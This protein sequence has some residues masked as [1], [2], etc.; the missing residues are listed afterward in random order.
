MS[1]SFDVDN[2]GYPPHNRTSFQHVQ[3][4]FPT[5]RIRRGTVPPAPWRVV[6]RDV[7]ALRYTTPDGHTRSVREMI[8]ASFTDAFLVAKGDVLVHEEYANGMSP[9]SHHLM[10][11]V[12]KTVLAMLAGIFVGRGAIRPDDRIA[13][14]VPELADTAFAQTT[15]RHALDMSAAVAYGEDYDDADADFWKETAVVGW[16]PAL[17]RS[18]SPRTLLDFARSLRTTEQR[19]GAGFHYRTVLTNVA[20]LALERATGR[21]LADLLDTELWSRLGCEQDAAIVADRAGFP[22]V[23]AG[24]NAC[25]RDLARFGRMIVGRGRIDGVQLVP[26]SWIEDT[27]RPD[28]E[29]VAAFAATEYGAGTP[30][31]QYRN[32]CWVNPPKDIVMAVG[33]HGQTI[34]MN[35]AR[36]VVIVKLSS[37]PRPVDVDMFR[38]TFAAM[39]AVAAAV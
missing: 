39:E 10:N 28:P 5:V 35:M 1:R 3:S 37:Q 2:W 23:G 19:D 34:H 21:P 22:Y 9:D 4:L 8:D 11:S 13:H 12:T 38:D 14:L 36:D 29:A 33:I 20:G 6:L 15:L 16:R 27:L 31:G 7:P 32:Q 24:M 30:G 25:A 18:D 26:E 17:V